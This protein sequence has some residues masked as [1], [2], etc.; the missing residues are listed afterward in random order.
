M[1][2]FL[3]YSLRRLL[4]I[5]VGELKPLLDSPSDALRRRFALSENVLREVQERIRDLEEFNLE[6]LTVDDQEHWLYSFAETFKARVQPLLSQDERR[7][8]RELAEVG[9]PI[10]TGS[11]KCQECEKK[12]SVY[13]NAL[14]DSKWVA[15]ALCS[16]HAEVEARKERK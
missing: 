7:R 3:P 15:R 13:V 4:K 12:A 5:W 14:V 16:E 8:L 11:T 6:G 9:A 1:L 10:L 2:S